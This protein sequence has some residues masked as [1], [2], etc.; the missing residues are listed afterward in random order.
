MTIDL[1]SI[2]PEI[3]VA[4]AGLLILMLSVFIGRK[5]DRAV[6]PLAAAGVVAAIAA[7]FI[8]NFYNQSVTFSGSF[9]TDNFSNFFRIFTLI[10]TLII[11][12]LS[13]FYIKGSSY[14]RRHLGEFY[15]L[16]LMQA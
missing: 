2:I 16:I 4:G 13:A 14:T 15:F 9:I 10:V 12:G 5:F 1:I 7:I 11:I 6:A 8:F 3:I